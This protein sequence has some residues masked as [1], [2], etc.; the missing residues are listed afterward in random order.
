M[1]KGVRTGGERRNVRK[2]KRKR[3]VAIKRPHPGAALVPYQ[4]LQG[5]RE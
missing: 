4:A 3:A 5:W 2:R 1:G